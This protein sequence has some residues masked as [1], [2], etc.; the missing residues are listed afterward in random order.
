MARAVSRA[1]ERESTDPGILPANQMQLF[2]FYKPSL[3]ATN[4][5]IEVTQH[6][7]ANGTTGSGHQTLDVLNTNDLNPGAVVGQEFTVVVPRFSLDP[8]IINSY[9]PPD[10]HQ[11]EGRILPHLV[12]NDPHFPWEIPAGVT[13]NKDGLSL[14]GTLDSCQK[15]INGQQ[16]T[17]F[18][19]MVP[20]VAVLVF[21]PED[22]HIATGAEMAP[23]NIPNFSTD[24]D[25]KNQ[26]PNG[27][28]TMTVPQYFTIPKSS[29]INYVA[30]YDNDET[31][32]DY[33]AM[34]NTPGTVDV[35]FPQKSLFQEFFA[36][37]DDVTNP[38][39]TRVEALK[40]LAHVRNINTK[41]F[42]DAGIEQEGLFSVVI[43][44]R[45]GPYQGQ[46]P[47]S[48]VCHLVSI[49]HV[50][51][52]LGSWLTTA[53]VVSDRV[54]MVSL[55]SWIYT[56]LPPDPV[57]FVV[58]MKNL[59]E[60]MQMLRTDNN[61][62]KAL[63]PPLSISTRP[64]TKK[65]Q[66]AGIMHHRLSSGYTLARWRT[67]SGEE[68]AAFNRGPLVPQPPP[69][70]PPGDLPDCSHTSQEY[71]LLDPQTGL[72]DLSY[73][74]AWQAG[75]LLAISDTVFSSALMRFR[76][77]IY[78]SSSHKTRMTTNNMTTR[79]DL[80]LSL[81]KSI[82]AVGSLTEGKTADPKRVN[83]TSSRAPAPGVNHPA[84]RPTML[85]N[86]KAAVAQNAQAGEDFYNEFNLQG[87]NN[88]EWAIVLAWMAEK[89]Y[90]GGIPP[91]YLIS[92]PAFLAPETLRFFYIDDFWL[93]CLLDGALSVAN[94]LDSDDDVVRREIKEVFNYYL[95]TVIPPAKIRPQ[96]PSYGFIIRS[97]LIKAMPD[98][99]ITVQWQIEDDR[100]D[101]CRWTRWDDQTLMCLLDRPPEQLLKITLAQP[102]HQ[103]RFAIGSHLDA[104]GVTLN[105]RTLYTQGDDKLTN[106]AGQPW[107]ETIIKNLKT[108][109]PD[110]AIPNSWYNFDTRCLKLV[111]MAQG[112]HD[113]LLF[114]PDNN[115]D[116]YIDPK[117]NSCELGL[118]LNDPACYF[119]IMPMTA[120]N[121]PPNPVFEDK[122]RQLYTRQVTPPDTDIT[123]TI[124]GKT[125]T[126]PHIHSILA[127]ATPA[128]RAAAPT[129]VTPLKTAPEPSPSTIHTTSSRPYTAPTAPRA[130]PRI[131]PITAR[132]PAPSALHHGISS[133]VSSHFDLTVFPDFQGPP[134][135]RYK[136][137]KYDPSDVVPADD[138]YFYDLIFY[139]HKKEAVFTSQWPLLRIDID[140]PT[141]TDP[142]PANPTVEALF[143]S[144]YDGP[145]LRM[146]S[147]QRFI[148]FLFHDDETGGKGNGTM[149]IELI[150]R[151]TNDGFAQVIN[152]RRT[153]E[154]GFRLAEANV[155]PIVVTTPVEI[156]GERRRLDV[157]KSKVIM[158]EWYATDA[159]PQG[160][161]VQTNY[162]VI[163]TD[164]NHPTH[165]S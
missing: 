112:I 96:I 85:A 48:Q 106:L 38:I 78:N 123:R 32:P 68:T 37:D 66:V 103:S 126:Q 81:Q 155:S 42:P 97:Q 117:P 118:E 56:A 101:V 50:D 10:G 79:V 1:R 125:K 153:T 138:P 141:V 35:I 90:L 122:I 98:L 46:L 165:S 91:Q 16:I 105:L 84:V 60:N 61:L 92:E 109:V 34:I 40:Y 110:P 132:A 22:L 160:E 43:S 62:L 64:I 30:G 80:L 55:H 158:T 24:A 161:G 29:H 45:T 13:K 28:F 107:G 143:T 145:G 135:I 139:I 69:R 52:T 20:W 14:G 104:T 54:A 95:S 4:Y 164:K 100:A 157:G 142:P 163:K 77:L 17:V 75:K 23:L 2:S 6:I 7:D 140:I 70:V 73:S 144:N 65:D 146:L 88:N 156:V 58:T 162:F 44:S 108:G 120:I 131:Q 63:K 39:K 150:P 15:T 36:A 147:N 33:Q 18:R 87:P 67:Q 76:S 21:D 82:S 12:F 159:F 72:M 25:V 3:L 11:D 51:S 113:Q 5:V 53:P 137:D 111:E 152:D 151:S 59:T 136:Q 47:R 26:K 124:L 99:K 128:A 149:H 121:P 119:E 57:D 115:G 148:P 83:P 134:K 41:G 129:R 89:L 74:S 102:L 133:N 31:N 27:V 93:D 49:E 71:Q 127:R 130:Q 116:A 19:S 86:I 154:L 94:H 9:Y 8:N 114:G